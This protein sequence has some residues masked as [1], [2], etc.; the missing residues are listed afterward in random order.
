MMALI[1][2]SLAGGALII[3]FMTLKAGKRSIAVAAIVLGSLGVLIGLGQA[4]YGFYTANLCQN[5]P[6]YAAS[7]PQ[8]QR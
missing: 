3:G 1:L 4:G 8:C 7:T 5:D 6:T 2:S